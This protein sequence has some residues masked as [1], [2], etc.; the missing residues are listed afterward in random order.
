MFSLLLFLVPVIQ[1]CNETKHRSFLTFALMDSKEVWTTD[2]RLRTTNGKTG[3][4][5]A[6]VF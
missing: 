1:I 2:V 5:R 6:K 3:H 4:M